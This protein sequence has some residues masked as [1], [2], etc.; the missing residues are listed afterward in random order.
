MFDDFTARHCKFGTWCNPVPCTRL[1]SSLCFSVQSDFV[2]RCEECCEF[3][4]EE[5]SDFSDAGLDEMGPHPLMEKIAS[6][7]AEE[8]DADKT[9]W[10]MDSMEDYIKATRYKV[11]LDDVVYRAIADG[12]FFQEK[13]RQKQTAIV[14]VSA[15]AARHFT[16]LG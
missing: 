11:C 14:Q 16:S 13:T 3:S 12:Y 2:R 5:E 1:V 10:L 8:T 7:C 9:M 15:I 6:V 4:E